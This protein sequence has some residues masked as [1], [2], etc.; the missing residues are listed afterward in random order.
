MTSDLYIADVGQDQFEEIDVLR[1]STPGGAN[2]GWKVM[3]GTRCF[4]TMGCPAG[5]PVCNA[6]G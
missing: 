3:E 5:T 2:L 4:S 6:P 1:A